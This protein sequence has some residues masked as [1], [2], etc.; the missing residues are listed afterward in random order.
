MEPR[1]GQISIFVKDQI[2]KWVDLGVRRGMGSGG[3][4]AYLAHLVRD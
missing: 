2:A 1:K 3:S 4:Q